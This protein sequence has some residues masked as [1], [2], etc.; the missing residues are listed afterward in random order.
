MDK[1]SD[2]QPQNQTMSFEDYKK[3]LA[4]C[5]AQAFAPTTPAYKSA[6]KEYEPDFEKYWREGWS[7]DTAASEMALGW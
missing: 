4:E 5:L 3:K 6:M 2:K 1:T 7:P